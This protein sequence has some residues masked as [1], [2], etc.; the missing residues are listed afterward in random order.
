M[1]GKILLV[2]LYGNF[3]YGNVLQRYALT[4]TLEGFG[5]EVHHLCRIHKA[6]SSLAMLKQKIKRVIK[7]ILALMGVKKYIEQFRKEARIS[8][9]KSAREKRFM[10]FQD[11]FTGTK[12][13][14]TFTEALRAEKSMWS[15]YDFAVVGSDQVWHNWTKSPEELAY[16]YLEF[17]EREKRVNYAPSFGFSHF[18]DAD[19]E[20][21]RKG[22]EGFER[23][24][25]REQ[26]MQPMIRA[27]TGQ[28][29]ELVLDPTL[30]L[31]AGQWQEVSSRPEYD[32]P[33]RYVLCYFLGE[34]TPE[35]SRAISD[36]AGGLPIMTISGKNNADSMRDFPR[37]LTHPGEFV[38]L[39]EHADFVCTDSFHGTAFSVI[40]RKNFMAFRRKKTGFE[41]MF[42]RIES[43]LSNLGLMNHVYDSGMT[44]RPD[45][46][47]S[48]AVTSRLEEMRGASLEYLRGCLKV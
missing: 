10:S 29:A 8:A 18:A 20:L 5:F 44:T 17:V 40:F 19:R 48:E 9:G 34:I 16:Y 15:G 21:H 43:L 42:G 11:K 28:N 31:D 47:N 30:L 41:D 25:C 46:L 39:L 23:V 22:L 35:Y 26:E 33:E 36:M 13:F 38:Y 45:A 24:S 12:I 4:K 37:Y 3:N 32:L 27:L 14:M 7:R 2:S 6:P 1:K